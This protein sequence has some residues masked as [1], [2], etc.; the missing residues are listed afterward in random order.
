MERESWLPAI[1]SQEI[2][3]VGIDSWR[4]ARCLP[5]SDHRIY[6]IADDFDN[7]SRE[8][9]MKRILAVATLLSILISELAG[10]DALSINPGLWEFKSSSTNPLTGQR[11]SETET[12]CVVEDK[13]DPAEMID[14]QDGC[15][16]TKSTLSGDTLT[17]SMSCKMQGGEMTMNA[18]YQSDGDSVDGTTKIN[19][20]FG[21]QTMTSDGS[22]SGQ[23]I[24][25]C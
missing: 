12:E 9:N 14:N 5:K 19:I 25:D 7:H 24:G 18:V 4:A 17:F 15:E 8:Q 3:P 20:S 11:E 1:I 2:G 21:T 23:R 10:A 16:I 6:T 22:F 13:L